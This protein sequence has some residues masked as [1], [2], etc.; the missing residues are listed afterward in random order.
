[1]I[2]GDILGRSAGDTI[3][4]LETLPRFLLDRRDL[5]SGRREEMGLMAL[6]VGDAALLAM[7]VA[8]AVVGVEVIVADRGP[9]RTDILG[10][11][12]PFATAVSICKSGA[13]ASGRIRSS[14]KGSSSPI[15]WIVIGTEGELLDWMRISDA[16]VAGVGSVPFAGIIGDL[17]C[18]IIAGDCIA[19]CGFGGGPI[20]PSDNGSGDIDSDELY[21]CGIRD[22]K[23]EFGDDRDC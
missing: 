6:L 16:G 10:V 8:W 19:E 13:A 9:L 22:V 2:L 14:S 11:N 4:L 12:S 7:G 3:L 21:R 5:I 20:R 15:S 23:G 18:A 17:L 1:M